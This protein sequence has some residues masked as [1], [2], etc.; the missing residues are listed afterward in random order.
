[1]IFDDEAMAHKKL[2]NIVINDKT[3]NPYISY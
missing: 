3:N 2:L 1:M